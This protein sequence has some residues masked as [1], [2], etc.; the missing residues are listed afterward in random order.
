MTLWYQI[1]SE[2]V[3]DGSRGLSHVPF[4]CIMD[5]IDNVTLLLSRFNTLLWGLLCQ[6][7]FSRVQY[8]YFSQNLPVL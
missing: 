2:L 8:V 7:C 1:R 6:I 4:V 5:A 3:P